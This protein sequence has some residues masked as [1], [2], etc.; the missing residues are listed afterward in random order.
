MALTTAG[1]DWL[2]TNAGVGGCFSPTGVTFQDADG[3]SWTMGTKDVVTS[4][5]GAHMAAK[6]DVIIVADT[7]YNGF[8][9]INGGDVG[10]ADVTY[11]Y[12]NDGHGGTPQYCAPA[13]N[14]ISATLTVDKNDCIAPCTVNGTVSWTN[15]GNAP[16]APMNLQVTVTGGT[17]A[18]V[19]TGVVINPGDTTIEYP[20]SI[21]GLV[22]GTYDICA[23]PDSGTTCQ[24]IVVSPTPAEIITTNIILTPPT[25]AEQCNVSVDVTYV[26]S[27]Q[28]S[29]TFTPEITVNEAHVLIDSDTLDPGASVVKTFE[30]TDMAIGTYTICAVPIGVTT[31]KTLTVG[32]QEAG[33]GG[34]LVIGLAFGAILMAGKKEENKKPGEK[35]KTTI[36]F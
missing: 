19:A 10:Y 29:G 16:S 23:S 4:F 9:A 20:F 13:A 26:N 31:C 14:V 3:V 32:A 7:T 35:R 18:T 33:I 27:G 12:N 25:C 2:A 1:K 30:L 5:V 6:D 34:L 11:V 17:P 8:K 21:S 22:I 28:T 24:T 36:G 15:N